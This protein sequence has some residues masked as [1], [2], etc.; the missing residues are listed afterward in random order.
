MNERQIKYQC[1]KVSH[2]FQ[3]Y[4]NVENKLHKHSLH[5]IL[6]QSIFES[7]FD[8][9]G[10]ILPQEIVPTF[11]L[12][13]GKLR[14]ICHHVLPTSSH[15]K[16][17]ARH[18]SVQLAIDVA[19][20]RDLQH[21]RFGDVAFLSGTISCTLRNAKQILS[22]IASRNENDLFQHNIRCKGIHAFKWPTE[23]TK[24]VLWTG[25]S[26]HPIWSSTPK[27]LAAEISCF[28]CHPIQTTKPRLRIFHF[29][30]NA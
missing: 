11:I 25:T 22:L 9:V 16:Q 2:L 27:I 18:L 28:H 23:L 10:V 13:V 3:K 1:T 20:F 4:K 12:L 19:K 7:M 21:N 30:I 15:T 5:V 8:S 24:F 14:E 17:N 6:Q 26:I 29:Y